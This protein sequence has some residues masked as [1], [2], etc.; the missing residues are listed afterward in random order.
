MSFTKRMLEEREALQHMALG[1]LCDAQALEE[2]EHHEA[3]YFDGGTEVQE[4]Y[5]LANARISNGE[6][7]LPDGVSR[8]DFTDVMKEVYI[9]NSG[10]D[11]CYACEKNMSD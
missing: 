1:I 2:C 9:E 4:A 10:R 8:R 5:K 3:I 7:E 6:L 11:D